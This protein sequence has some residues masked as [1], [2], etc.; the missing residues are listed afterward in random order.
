MNSF[1]EQ[2]LGI[3]TQAKLERW[4]R[5]QVEYGFDF[6]YR[7]SECGRG[8]VDGKGR[9]VEMDVSATAM[10]VQPNP[11]KRPTRRDGC[12][13]YDGLQS[14]MYLTAK[15]HSPPSPATSPK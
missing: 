11:L 7:V 9:L 4:A 8:V 12:I 3:T 6:Y 2:S 5:C 10:M 1:L 15:S 14:S 13:I